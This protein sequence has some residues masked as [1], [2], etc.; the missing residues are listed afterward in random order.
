MRSGPTR[1]NFFSIGYDVVS[2]QIIKAALQIEGI[3][4]PLELAKNFNLAAEASKRVA[5]AVKTTESAV[6]SASAETYELS[7]N[8]KRLSADLTDSNNA[9]DRKTAAAVEATRAQRL[10]ASALSDTAPALDGAGK[11]TES[12]AEAKRRLAKEQYAVNSRV[13]EFGRAFQDVYQGGLAGG[14]NNIERLVGGAGKWAGILTAVG[15]LVYAFKDQFAE[16]AKAMGLFGDQM[17]DG[18]IPM[19]ERLAARIKELEG[20]SIKVAAD[21]TELDNAKKSL[22]S[23]EAGLAAFK[24][25]QRE[26]TGAEA[27][28]AGKAIG[29]QITEAEGGRAGVS[30]DLKSSLLK[31]LKKV[32]PE[33][34]AAVK[35]YRDEIASLKRLSEMGTEDAVAALPLQRRRVADAVRR[36]NLVNQNT[37]KKAGAMAATL[38]ENA[39]SGTDSGREQ[40]AGQLKAAGRGKLGEAVAGISVESLRE[41]ER[42][43][44]DLEESIE[45]MREAK[46]ART[47][48]ENQEAEQLNVE[49]KRV[50]DLAEE[51]RQAEEKADKQIAKDMADQAQESRERRDDEAVALMSTSNI[52]ENA[53]IAAA[54]ARANADR[55]GRVETINPRTMRREMVDPFAALSDDATMAARQQGVTQ[56]N[57]RGVGVQIAGQAFSQVDEIIEAN[58]QGLAASG[59]GLDAT[60]INQ[61]AIAATLLAVQEANGRIEQVEARA[62]ELLGLAQDQ[63]RIGRPNRGTNLRRGR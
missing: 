15:V 46:K 7:N 5:A 19:V 29:E 36:L 37:G 28:D 13:L 34:I 17:R 3:E 47:K 33:Y 48:R 56:P 26:T 18:A 9:L 59:R 2:D 54:M 10:M 57:A 52:D 62:R 63:V 4:K 24:K 1:G 51:R 49:G 39:E 21:V 23:L 55:T 31:D 11:K 25:M 42:V 6:V 45:K 43:D 32:D 16:A 14:L 38:I 8:Y 40:L 61:R 50:E 44:R 53:L 20:K 60:T 58:R 27:K 30:K 12:L 22:E 35:E 41:D